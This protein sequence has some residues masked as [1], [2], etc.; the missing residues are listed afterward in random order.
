MA[1]ISRHHLPTLKCLKSE[2][3]TPRSFA[4]SHDF[5]FLAQSLCSEQMLRTI[6]VLKNQSVYE[7]EQAQGPQSAK[8]HA[9]I[10]PLSAHSCCT[11][12]QFDAE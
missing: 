11:L 7:L 6:T 8:G 12:T 3:M 9:K 1:D 4:D 5:P 2:L 10:F